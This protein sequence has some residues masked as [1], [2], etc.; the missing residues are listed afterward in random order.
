MGEIYM[1]ENII[2]GKKYIGQT[3][4]TAIDRFR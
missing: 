4:K 3:S 2:N 1:I